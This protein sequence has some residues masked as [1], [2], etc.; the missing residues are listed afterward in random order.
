MN[1]SSYLDQKVSNLTTNITA[2]ADS[3]SKRVERQTTDQQLK[4]ASNKDQF[5]FNAELQN[6]IEEST[7]LLQHQDVE[8]ALVKLFTSKIEENKT[9]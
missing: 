1:R 3:R 8:V 7:E 6:S 9:C 5:L 4:L 2:K